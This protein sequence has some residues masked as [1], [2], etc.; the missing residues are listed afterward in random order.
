M[1]PTLAPMRATPPDSGNASPMAATIRSAT[2]VM[3]STS[4]TG[5]VSTANSSPPTRATVSELRKAS[6]SRSATAWSSSSPA[7]W[8]KA[9]LLALKPSRSM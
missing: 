7:A 5:S 3:S 9:S 8:P 1:M 6:L 4:F 2:M